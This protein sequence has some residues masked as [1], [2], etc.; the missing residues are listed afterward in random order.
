MVGASFNV[1][2]D[3]YLGMIDTENLKIIVVEVSKI[4][5]S[6]NY[7][8]IIDLF[9]EGSKIKFQQKRGETMEDVKGKMDDGRKALLLVLINHR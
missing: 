1:Q 3:K 4:S 5:N 6:K 7:Y 9:F 2:H 8:T